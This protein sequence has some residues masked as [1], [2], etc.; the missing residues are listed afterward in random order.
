MS[1]KFQKPRGTIDILP[2]DI[3]IWHKIEETARKICKKYGFEEIRFPTFEQIDLFQ[4]GV[5]NTTDVVQKE[6][7]TF[8]DKEGR[9]FALRPEGTA[10]IVRSIIENGKCSDAMPLKL[11][12]LINCFRYEKPQAGAAGNSTNSERSFSVRNPL[13]PTRKSFRSHTN[14]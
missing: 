4:R 9:Q 11:Y 8:S 3:A 5:G 12:Y 10:C 1:G 14:S 2:K 13:Q 7:Y 6:M